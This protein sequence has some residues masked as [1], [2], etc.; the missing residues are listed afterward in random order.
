MDPFKGACS[1][2][3]RYGYLSNTQ[4]KKLKDFDYENPIFVRAC[5][6]YQENDLLVEQLKNQLQDQPL[7]PNGLFGEATWMAMRMP[8]CKVKDNA[9]SVATAVGSG[10]FR[11][12][13]PGYPDAHGAVCKIQ[14]SGMPSGW[15][16]HAKAICMIA[17]AE[18]AKVGFLWI[19]VDDD[20]KDIITGE[21]RSDLRVNTTLRWR[22]GNGWIGLATVGSG[23][24]TCTYHFPTLYLDPYYGTN[25]SSDQVYIHQ[26][27]ALLMHELGH[28]LTLQHRRGGIMNPGILNWSSSPPT[29][30]GDPHQ[31]T[32]NVLYS[33][34]EIEVPGGFE[35][36]QPPPP[37]GSGVPGLYQ[38]VGEA[39]EAFGYGE[40]VLVQPIRIQ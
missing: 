25:F 36:P 16:K 6:K 3:K 2:L 20:G 40:R 18:Y 4:L 11:G 22:R 24:E 17:Q 12:C 29:W 8:R 7:L 10:G 5:Q 30:Q 35:P 21:D 9:P 28:N 27:A 26:H 37:D 32:L 14:S 15:R 34:E 38:P 39:Y 19:F 23:R 1:F 31:G 33:G 13:I